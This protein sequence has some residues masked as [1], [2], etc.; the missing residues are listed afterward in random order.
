MLSSSRID[1]NDGFKLRRKVD[2]NSTSDEE[3]IEKL[4][5][6]RTMIMMM[7]LSGSK[8]V[9]TPQMLTTS[10]AVRRQRVR[11]TD[12]EERNARSG[13]GIFRP[14]QPNVDFV[15]HGGADCVAISDFQ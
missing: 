12:A 1:W 9:S 4:G 11:G 13:F 7:S 5:I 15:I 8:P 10:S 6:G 14:G 2:C 3:H